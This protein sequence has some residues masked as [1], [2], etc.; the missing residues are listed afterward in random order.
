MSD[1]GQ[2]NQEDIIKEEKEREMA[3]EIDDGALDQFISENSE[4]LIAEF[5]DNYN[6]EWRSYCKEKFNEVN[7]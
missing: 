5:I 6:S 1:P 4:G 2:D 3:N 7:E